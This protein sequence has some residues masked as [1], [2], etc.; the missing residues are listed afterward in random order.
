V[1]KNLAFFAL[2]GAVLLS[3]LSAPALAT[4]SIEPTYLKLPASNKTSTEFSITVVPELGEEYKYVTLLAA[5]PNEGEISWTKKSLLVG[6]RASTRL[7]LSPRTPGEYVLRISLSGSGVLPQEEYVEVV[8]EEIANNTRLLSEISGYRGRVETVSRA[9]S[10]LDRE[11][12]SDLFARLEDANSTVNLAEESYYEAKY[13]FTRNALSKLSAD[14]P[15]LETEVSVLRKDANPLFGSFPFPS[16]TLSVDLIILIIILL[17][18][19]TLTAKAFI[20]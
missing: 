18:I 6:R 15:L 10:E 12:Y 9:L 20:F 8:V 2:L 1:G 11:K 5:W 19:V 14:V 4:L 17:F 3:L 7:S 16:G 13:S